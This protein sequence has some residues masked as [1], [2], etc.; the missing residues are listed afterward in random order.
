MKIAICC[1]GLLLAVCVGMVSGQRT[2]VQSAVATARTITVAT[3]PNAVIWIDDIRRGTTDAGGRLAA[4]KISSG[5]HTLRTRASG[6]KESSVPVTAAQRGEIRVRLLRTT[7]E[8]ELAFQQAETARDAAKD[9]ESRQKAVDLYRRT[10]R[11][12]P[13][14]PAAHVGLARVLLDLNDIDGALAEIESARRD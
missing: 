5:A 7:D 1:A 4:L 9:Q 2:G 3:E 12:R 8:S 11:L 14:F 10:L 6:F 13:G